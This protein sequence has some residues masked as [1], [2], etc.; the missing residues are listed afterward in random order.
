MCEPVTATLGLT[1]MQTAVLGTM[2]VGTAVSAY[3]AYNQAKASK[4]VARNN[5]A[6]AELAA[7]DAEKRGETEA[8]MAQRRARQVMGAQ[9][10]AFSARGI[11]IDS[12][13][14]G[15]LIDQTDFFG[16]SDAATARTN[17]RKDA[18]GYRSQ[19]LNYQTQA[20]AIN[21]GLTA[22]STLLGGASDVAGKWYA[23]KG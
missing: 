11:D 19:G 21:P 20:N 14:A 23:W 13:T 7:Q 5:A 22:A 1:A 9:R 2:A 6:T 18:R 10:A 8:Q 15:D 3:G 16:Q 4:A 17:A 12:G